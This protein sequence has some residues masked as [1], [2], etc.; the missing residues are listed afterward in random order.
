MAFAPIGEYR[1]VYV[2]GTNETV[3]SNFRGLAE[4][5]ARWPNPNGDFPVMTALICAIWWYLDCPDDFETFQ[6]R[7]HEIEQI[8]AAPKDADAVDPTAPV[9]V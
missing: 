7:V 8:N 9:A 4:V 1:V 5:E 2:D 3:K 6:R